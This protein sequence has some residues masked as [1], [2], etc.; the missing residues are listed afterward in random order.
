M[1][2]TAI[3]VKVSVTIIMVSVLTSCYVREVCRATQGKIDFFRE[4]KFVRIARYGKKIQMNE[5]VCPAYSDCRI[6]LST[7]KFITDYCD[8]ALGVTSPAEKYILP[9]G[10][11]F[12]LYL[13]ELFP[14]KY[15]RWK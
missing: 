8:R 5:G 1:P 6:G 11:N 2:T 9:A 12:S 7:D 13:I 4:P 15:G 3:A 10:N 14:D